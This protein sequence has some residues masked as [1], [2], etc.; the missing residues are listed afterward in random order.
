LK[1]INMIQKRKE[2]KMSDNNKKIFDVLLEFDDEATQRKDN[3]EIAKQL[4]KEIENEKKAM[5]RQEIYDKIFKLL[6]KEQFHIQNRF[7]FG[8]IDLETFEELSSARYNEYQEYVKDLALASDNE[9]NEKMS[10]I[11]NANIE[12]F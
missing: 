3:A 12:T 8:E 7:E 11:I 10:F 5:T 4:E 6:E 2:E 1:I 9:L